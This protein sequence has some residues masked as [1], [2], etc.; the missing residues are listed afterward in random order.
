MKHIK[1]YKCID[2]C[3]LVNPE[4]DS[5]T[6]GQ[7]NFD[8][9]V[10]II[11]WRNDMI[12]VQLDIYIKIFISPHLPELIQNTALLKCK[13]ESHKTSTIKHEEIFISWQCKYF[14]NRY[15]KYKPQSIKIQIC[16]GE[17]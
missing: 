13:P 6:Y 1:K 8:K 2:Q 17:K 11:K 14:L 15:A 4:I 16:L 3:K 5:N 9:F 12:L 7:I 10:K